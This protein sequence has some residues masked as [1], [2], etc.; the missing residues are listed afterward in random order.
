MDLGGYSDVSQILRVAIIYLF[1]LLMLRFAGKRRLMRL[2]AFDLLIVIALGSAVGDVMI[3]PEH[4]ASLGDSMIAIFVVVVLQVLITKAME[5]SKL[6]D[7]IV[8]GRGTILIR[9]GK[10]NEGN[11]NGEDL[12]KDELMEM[13]EEKGVARIS[14]VKE[15]ILE[16]SGDLAVIRKR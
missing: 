2:S 14:E 16:P 6:V 12:T 9:N 7:Y 15:A 3:Y 5:R 11:M 10:L 1:A 13:L 4:I 8:R